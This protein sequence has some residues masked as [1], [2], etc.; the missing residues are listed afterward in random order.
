[1]PTAF[2]RR[3]RGQC[4][5][6]D[7]RSA[8]LVASRVTGN[9]ASDGGGIF[10]SPGTASVTLTST[11]VSGNTPNQCRPVGAVPGCVN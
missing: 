7:H 5:A 8:N 6:G 10:V 1:M 2:E 11:T 3:Q 4:D 9:T